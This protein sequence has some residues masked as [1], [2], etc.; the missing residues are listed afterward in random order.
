MRH[1]YKTFFFIAGMALL[2]SCEP[3]MDS[4]TP[5]AG[6]ADFSRYVALGNSL[7][8]GYSNSALYKSGQSYAYPNLIAQQ[9]KLAGGG[10]FVT[11]IVD[12]EDGLLAGKLMLGISTN[13][14][15]VA[16][17]GPV[18]AGGTPTGFPAALAPVGY[19][20]NNFGVPGAKS[21]HL[22]APG[23]GNPAGLAAEPPT[24]NPYFV[25][26]ASSPTTSVLADAMAANPTFFSL[27]IGNNDVLGYSTSGG[28]GDV[29]TSQE[30][31]TGA[32]TAIVTNMTANGSK[33]IIANIPDVTSVPFFTTIPFN[34]LVLTQ[35]EQVDALNAAYH[36]GAF[37]ISFALGQ[38]AFVIADPTSPI[39]MRQIRP[40]EMVLLT[41]PQD[42]LRCAGWG[43]QKPIPGQYTLVDSEISAVQ[44]ATAAFN[45]TIKGLAESKGLAFADVNTLLK[46]VKTGLVYDGMRF[47]VTYVTG[48]TFSLDGVHL[49]PRGNA[50]VANFFIEAINSKYGSGIPLVNVGDYPGIIFP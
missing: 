21:Y 20:V 34:G 40:T 5:T 26:F 13:C 31:F 35:Q 27:W 15:G 41:L 44:T 12:N 23:Y 46:K 4:F 9:M 39:G 25:R 47:S 30:M 1:I 48:G 49:T 7:T 18:S 14:L 50:I 17:L 28:L 33:G 16:S 24:A 2:A 3:K 42:S 37:G 32:L 22:L 43:S 36:N 19:A 6:S 29:I 8:S 10:E 38:N 11:P 45:E